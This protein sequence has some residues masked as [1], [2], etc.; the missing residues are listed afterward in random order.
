MHYQERSLA[1]IQSMH[2][3]NGCLRVLCPM[4]V[5]KLLRVL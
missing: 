5:E 1:K 3:V 4:D 2:F